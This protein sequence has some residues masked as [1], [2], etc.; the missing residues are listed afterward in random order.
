VDSHPRNWAALHGHAVEFHL[1]NARAWADATTGLDL[2]T[3]V[4]PDFV[5]GPAALT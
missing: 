3:Q 5:P 4:D 2:A 1:R